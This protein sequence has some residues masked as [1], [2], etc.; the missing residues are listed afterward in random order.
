MKSDFNVFDFVGGV[1]Q[2][3]MN[4][5]PSEQVAE[6]IRKLKAKLEGS[7][8]KSTVAIEAM[9][10]V[11]A[12]V[13]ADIKEDREAEYGRERRFPKVRKGLTLAGSVGCGKSVAMKC[14]RKITNCVYVSIPELA[15]SFASNGSKAI[16][17]Q[18][19]T[20]RKESLI[21]D[22]LGAEQTMKSFGQAF[23][24]EE[25]LMERYN[26]WQSKRVLTHFSTNMSGAD[27]TE[28]YGERISDRIREMTEICVIKEKSLRN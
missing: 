16:I 19:D 4:D 17:D 13:L 14:L 15:L 11:A 3:Q 20:Y 8:M 26:V 18:M 28:R 22:D 27:I 25:I 21:I 23:P 5:A 24:I 1:K 9:I 2:H 7:S 12:R 10:P 6:S